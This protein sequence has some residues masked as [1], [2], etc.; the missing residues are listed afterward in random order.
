[1]IRIL[2]RKTKRTKTYIR[3]EFDHEGKVYQK[4]LILGKALYE[5]LTEKEIFSR[6]RGK[7]NSERH[8]MST[9][10]PEVNESKNED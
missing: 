1:M 3:F 9:P 10:E 2:D 5:V 7:A 6:V 4:T 8:K